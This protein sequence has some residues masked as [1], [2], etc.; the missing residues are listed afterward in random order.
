M[1]IA[2]VQSTEKIVTGVNNTTLAF[3]SNLT[4]ANLL[5]VSH[6]HWVEPA[7]AISTPTDTLSHTYVGMVTEQTINTNAKLRSFYVADCTGGADTVTF[8]AAG[9]DNGDLALVIAE[10]SGAATVSPLGVTSSANDTSGT[11]TAVN[12]GATA[13]LDQAT[14]MLW[15]GMNYSGDNTTITETGG[16]TLVQE[17]EGGTA[18]MPI[19][20]TYE[21]TTVDTGQAATWT[22]GAGRQWQAH[23]AFFKATVAGGGIAVPIVT[24][25]FRARWG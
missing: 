10:F 21:L 2:L 16:A 5:C 1:A 17:H 15:G 7:A 25:Q 20:T 8:D 23:I 11:S 19:G 13:Q 18:D 6:S 12:S 4:A 3:A 14:G 24:R 9:T 22:L